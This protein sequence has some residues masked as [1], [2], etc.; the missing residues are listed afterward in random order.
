M[1]RVEGVLSLSDVMYQFPP[2]YMGQ[3]VDEAL[4]YRDQVSQGSR[5]SLN[6]A[7]NNS[8]IRLDGFRDVSKADA[9]TLAEPVFGELVGGNERLLRSVWRT[10]MESREPLRGQVADVLDR[11]G[12]STE[13]IQGKG[14]EGIAVWEEEDWVA[15]VG[16]H[17]GG[18]GGCRQ[19]RR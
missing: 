5:D 12:I 16:D 1:E 15:K 6:A 2:G 19:A 13:G 10:W 18:G 11:L 4:Q 3:V 7:I 9:D 14:E 17:S 8:G